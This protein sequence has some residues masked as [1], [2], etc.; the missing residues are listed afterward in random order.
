MYFIIFLKRLL[1]NTRSRCLRGIPWTWYAKFIK[2]TESLGSRREVIGSVIYRTFFRRI[3]RKEV[4]LCGLNPGDRV[5]QIG[6][7]SLPQTVLY[8][9]ELGANVEALDNDPEAVVNASQYLRRLNHDGRVSVR[10]ADGLETDCNDADAVWLSFVVHPKEEVL[11]RAFASLKEGGRLVYRN[12]VGLLSYLIP[13]PRVEPDSIAPSFPV[14]KVR[15]FPGMETVVITK[16]PRKAI[17]PGGEE[18]SA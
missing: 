7:G 1:P 17:A 10:Q 8:L 3:T 4:P 9:A 11:R 18:D 15:Y 14:K 16:T 2:K 13:E 12:P 6:V 5:I